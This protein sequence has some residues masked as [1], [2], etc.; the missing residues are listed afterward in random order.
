MDRQYNLHTCHTKSMHSA[1]F[2]GIYFNLLLIIN[3][4]SEVYSIYTISLM[5]GVKQ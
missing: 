3:N 2:I 5:D 4:G 1:V